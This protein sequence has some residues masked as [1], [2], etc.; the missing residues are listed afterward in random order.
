MRPEAGPRLGTA[1]RGS[2]ATARPPRRA[3]RR[4]DDGAA[5]RTTLSAAGRR[6]SRTDP[7]G[8]GCA[9]K[10]GPGDERIEQEPECR[11]RPRLPSPGPVASEPQQVRAHPRER[12]VLGHP[13]GPDGALE[14]STR[15][16]LE[17]DV[18]VP[19]LPAGIPHDAVPDPRRYEEHASGRE[20]QPAASAR[21]MASRPSITVTCSSSRA[22]TPTGSRESRTGCIHTSGPTVRAAA[23]AEQRPIDRIRILRGDPCGRDACLPAE[24]PFLAS[25]SRR[26]WQAAR[27]SQG[28][29]PG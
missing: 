6:L 25:S 13:S 18:P 24:G 15:V 16:D 9:W 17:T 29:E 20:F 2:C 1:A 7:N 19:A 22:T 11:L 21:P 14:S 12:V 23:S 10:E 5:W 4:R 8:H 3:P 26:A 28:S 27:S